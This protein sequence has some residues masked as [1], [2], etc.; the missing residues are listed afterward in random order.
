[1]S[2]S[3]LTSRTISPIIANDDD[4]DPHHLSSQLSESDVDIEL[5]LDLEAELAKLKGRKT[6]RFNGTP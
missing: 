5:E 4:D 3:T 1:M 2:S 6:E